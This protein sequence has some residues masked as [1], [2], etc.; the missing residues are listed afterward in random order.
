MSGLPGP[1]VSPMPSPGSQLSSVR[2][3]ERK[4]SVMKRRPGPGDMRPVML[5]QYPCEY[6]SAASPCSTSAGMPKVP[7]SSGVHVSRSWLTANC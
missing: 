1:V 4:I 3:F 5:Y 6:R 2:S 7:V